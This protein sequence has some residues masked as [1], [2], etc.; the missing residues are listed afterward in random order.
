MTEERMISPEGALAILDEVAAGVSAP[1]KIHKRIEESTQ[2]LNA[3]LGAWNEAK[4]M[5]VS[6]QEEVTAARE[7][8]EALRKENR[9]LQEAS[10]AELKSGKAELE[11]PEE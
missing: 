11:Q 8:I 2:L 10:A 5:V 1:R 7:T 9:A 6:L 4:K 3:V